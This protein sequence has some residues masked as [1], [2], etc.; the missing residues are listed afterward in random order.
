MNLVAQQRTARLLQTMNLGGANG[1]G[2]G[3]FYSAVTTFSGKYRIN[4]RMTSM[5]AVEPW[6]FVCTQD[7]TNRKE[8]C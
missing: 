1:F 7:I 2:L 8:R 6:A 3:A 5:S 4:Y